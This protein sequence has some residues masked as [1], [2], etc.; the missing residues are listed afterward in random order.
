PTAQ[1]PLGKIPALE[2]DTGP[3]LFDSRVICQFFDNRAGGKLYPAAP[4]L[5]D[6]LTLEAIG[7]GIVDAAILIV[8][9]QRIRPENIRMQAWVDG[10]WSKVAR[11]LDALEA[12]WGDYLSGPFDMGQVSLACALSYLDFRHTGRNWRE[13]HPSLAKWEAAFATRDSMKATVPVE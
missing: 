5:W 4:R 9:E 8:Y 10:Q 3:A 2:R 6:C 12:D 1:N 7:D 13:N 11:A